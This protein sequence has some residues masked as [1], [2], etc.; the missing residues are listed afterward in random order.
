MPKPMKNL[1][2]AFAFLFVALCSGFLGIT[3]A[4]AGLDNAT[5]NQIA[6]NS[7]QNENQAGF[8]TNKTP[9]KTDNSEPLTAVAVA[10]MTAN[11]V[12][13]TTPK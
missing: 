11:S 5:T 1:I 6:N 2:L 8:L 3:F 10:A 9:L 4:L 13:E 7:T 12:V